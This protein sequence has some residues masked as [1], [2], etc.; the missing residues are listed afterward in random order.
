[1]NPKQ[2]SPRNLAG[3]LLALAATLSLSSSATAQTPYKDPG[4]NFTISVP[5]GWHPESRPGSPQVIF[6]RGE[7]HVDVSMTVMKSQDGSTPD[8]TYDLH[9]YVQQ[10]TQ[11]CTNPQF[12]AQDVK[13]DIDGVPAVLTVFTC[14]DPDVGS[15]LKLVK[16]ATI[17]GRI[18]VFMQEAAATDFKAA[19]PE[20]NAIST[21]LHLSAS[22]TGGA[23]S[24]KAAP[25]KS[26][27]A[28]KSSAPRQAQQASNARSDNSV[29]PFGS[30]AGNLYRDPRGLF[31]LTIPDGWTP[32]PQGN[33]GDAG[34]VVAQ[35][36]TGITMAYF[37]EYNGGGQPSAIVAD[38]ENQFRSQFP[39]F[40]IGAHGDMNFNGYA[41]SSVVCYGTNPKGVPVTL[42]I[43]GVAGPN[44]HSY[45]MI[46]RVPRTDEQSVN[47]TFLAIMQ[48]V[49]LAA[50][51]AA[52]APAT[53]WASSS[54]SN[55]KVTNVGSRTASNA[56]A[57]MASS[58]VSGWVTYQDPVEK[59]YSVEVPQGW[60][61]NGGIFRV[62]YSDR[63]PMIDVT[64]PDGQINIRVGDIVIPPF[65]TPMQGHPEGQPYPLGAQ[66]SPM[67][68]RYRNGQ[69]F[70]EIYGRGR[71]ARLCDSLRPEQDAV[72]QAQGG[73]AL[74]EEKLM[75]AQQ[76]SGAPQQS[77][78]Q[79]SY[80]CGSA[81]GPRTAVVFAQ[82]HMVGNSIW[83]ASTD[84]YVAPQD[85]LAVAQN[86]LAHLENSI[87]FNA[88]WIP[89]DRQLDAEGLEYQKQRQAQRRA[90][91]YAQVQQ[92]EQKMQGMRN[93]VAAFE[94][95]QA[96]RQSQFQA[97]DN[98]LI[99]VTPTVD[100]FGVEHDVST[101]PKYN[102]YRNP[103]TGD[104]VN[105]NALPG[106][107][108]QQLT[109]I[110]QN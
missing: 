84:S 57:Q 102:Y 16:V 54:N 49:K 106:P 48:S 19:I 91:I 39:D 46:S 107:G 95:G 109:P 104:V 50:E 38:Y 93:Q 1:M 59:A 82:T 4:G 42:V 97:F 12:Q 40:T 73:K 53:P 43:V 25:A 15:D 90:D 2:T 74:F 41:A 26:S 23:T 87:Q 9:Y 21:S 65:F 47:P 7:G 36:T 80:A 24:S 108:W 32:L 13:D 63:R 64:S 28:S 11:G 20:I 30:N 103:G 70:A 14:T 94:R 58:S 34:V 98:A 22:V 6:R 100:S 85:K 75:Q 10:I 67:V 3:L 33:N 88:Q 72:P 44:G 86:I 83:I 17:N 60:R 31:S 8:A 37:G 89:Y 66:A 76:Q 69:Q 51:A 61:V 5:A 62:G 78:G 105:S 18:L 68:A 110:P 71:F 96:Q 99:G 79:V 52:P 56:N 101:G 92:A 29:Q 55:G 81:L 27:S 35:T 45:K 77:V